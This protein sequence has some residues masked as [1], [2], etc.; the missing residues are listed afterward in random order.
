ML[1]WEGVCQVGAWILVTGSWQGRR[2]AV[3]LLLACCRCCREKRPASPS[4]CSTI[5]SNTH[6]VCLTKSSYSCP[7]RT[8][9]G[10]SLAGMSGAAR[11]LRCAGE[12]LGGGLQTK[13]GAAT[14]VTAGTRLHSHMPCFHQLLQ[15]LHGSSG[16]HFYKRSKL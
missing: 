14:Q 15:Q 3:T 6:H 9:C 2:E 11:C 16:W 8:S 7:N 5:P 1:T 10:S 13:V 4:V 12:E